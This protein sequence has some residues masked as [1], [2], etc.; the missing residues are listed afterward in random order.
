MR[1]WSSWLRMPCTGLSAIMRICT[2]TWRIR[3]GLD[4]GLSFATDIV[5]EQDLTDLRYLYQYGEY[6]SDTEL[7]LAA[8]YEQS[9]PRKPLT[10]WHTPIRK[11][12]RKGF[13]V[14]GRD[15]SKKTDSGG[16]IPAGL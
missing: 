4:P 2:V 9:A 10:R 12:Y 5:M 8:L 6:V 3:E 13:E 14:M 7:K 1:L 11:G 16:G 15:L